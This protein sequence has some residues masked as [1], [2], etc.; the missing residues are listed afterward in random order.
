MHALAVAMGTAMAGQ[1]GS[2]GAG[3]R[4]AGCGEAAALCGTAAV[5]ARSVSRTPGRDSPHAACEHARVSRPA[6]PPGSGWA[7]R[8][9]GPVGP[10]CGIGPARAG[11]E[12]RRAVAAEEDADG[13]WCAVRPMCVPPASRRDRGGAALCRPRDVTAFPAG[14]GGGRAPC[15]PCVCRRR[16]VTIAAGRRDRGGPADSRQHSQP[17]SGPPAGTLPAPPAGGVAVGM[18]AAI[19]GWEC[20]LDSKGAHV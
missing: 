5:R 2:S 16:C 3:V 13:L 7:A 12:T 17:S 20:E 10:A 8:I 19:A 15:G 4:W 14:A 18:G 11:G 1:R 6:L 9:C